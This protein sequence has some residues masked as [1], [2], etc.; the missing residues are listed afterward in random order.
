[1]LRIWPIPQVDVLKHQASDRRHI[2]VKATPNLSRCGDHDASFGCEIPMDRLSPHPSRL[3]LGLVTAVFFGSWSLLG[4]SVYYHCRWDKGW[5]CWDILW[6]ESSFF[7]ALFG[8]LMLANSGNH[9]YNLYQ[10]DS[11]SQTLPLTERGWGLQETLLAPR[12][13]HLPKRQILW[14]C[15]GIRASKAYHEGILSDSPSR[16]NIWNFR[17]QLAGIGLIEDLEW[18]NTTLQQHQWTMP[19]DTALFRITQAGPHKIKR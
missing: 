5:S 17:A 15:Y 4:C 7:T 13:I 11:W 10:Y 19:C 1:M 12:I 14:E 3:Y 18:G 9:E 8:N 2:A 16:I 6:E